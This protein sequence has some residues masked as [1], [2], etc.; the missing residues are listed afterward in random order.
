MYFGGQAGELTALPDSLAGLKERGGEK[1]EGKTGKG[2][3]NGEGPPMFEV[4]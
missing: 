1:G 4:R 3:R 2:R